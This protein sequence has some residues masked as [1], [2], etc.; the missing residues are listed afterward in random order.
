MCVGDSGRLQLG[1][2][3]YPRSPGDDGV[4]MGKAAVL[5]L[6]RADTALTLALAAIVQSW[7]KPAVDAG[8]R[9]G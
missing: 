5:R 1:Q 9:G 7:V 6:E 8:P 2:G 3:F 4:W